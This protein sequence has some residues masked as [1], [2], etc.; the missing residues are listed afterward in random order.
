MNLWAKLVSATQNVLDRIE[1]VINKINSQIFGDDIQEIT[2]SDETEI[3]MYDTSSVLIRKYETLSEKE[4]Q[5]VDKFISKIDISNFE[6]LITY[7]RNQNKISTVLTE[8]LLKTFHDIKEF[9]VDKDI[10]HEEKL[11][12]R[13][14]MEVINEQLTIYKE[15]LEKIN[16]ELELSIVALIKV[17]D[18]ER[19]RLSI[20]EIFDVAERIH[21]KSINRALNEAINRMKVCK[22]VVETQLKTIDNWEPVKQ[23]LSN[24][25][26]AYK[27]TAKEPEIEEK[28]RELLE[29]KMKELLQR[30]QVIFG[31][32]NSSTKEGEEDKE[33]K[34]L[35]EIKTKL[36]I[37]AYTQRDKIEVIRNR[38]KEIAESEEKVK[39]KEA[40][41][42]ELEEIKIRL[43]VFGYY[44]QDEDWK[45]YYETK[46]EVLT[47]DI[48]QI[49]EIP[50]DIEKLNKEELKYYERIIQ[51]KTEEIRTGRNPELNRAFGTENLKIVIRQIK[52][53][54]KG[55]S[56]T[57]N[58]ETILKDIM[59]LRLL[60]A[61]DKEFGVEEIVIKKAQGMTEV[62][63]SFIEWADNVP[64]KTIMQIQRNPE[65][66]FYREKMLIAS[67]NPFIKLF[68][69]CNYLPSDIEEKTTHIVPEGIVRIGN[70][71]YYSEQDIYYYND[72]YTCIVLPST[73]KRLKSMAFR[74]RETKDI[75][76][77]TS[78]N[79]I[80]HIEF[81]DELEEID[82]DVFSYTGYGKM[83]REVLED[84]MKIIPEE[85]PKD[86]V[87]RIKK[88]EALKKR[89]GHYEKYM[90]EMDELEEEI[91]IINAQIKNPPVKDEV[92]I[93]MD[94]LYNKFIFYSIRYKII[95]KYRETPI[96]DSRYEN[97]KNSIYELKFIRLMLL[98]KAGHE[99][100]FKYLDKDSEE[101]KYF[102]EL[103]RM[104]VEE[105]V[106]ESN[107][108]ITTAFGM[109]NKKEA[110]SIIMSLLDKPDVFQDANALKLLFAFENGG[111]ETANI[112]LPK[113]EVLRAGC[114]RYYLL[115][116]WGE[117]IPLSSIIKMM[118]DPEYKNYLENGRY[119]LC[120]DN[121][122]I[123]LVELYNYKKKEIDDKKP[124]TYRFLEGIEWID[125]PYYDRFGIDTDTA[126]IIREGGYTRVVLPS[127]LKRITGGDYYETGRSAFSR[128]ENGKIEEVV[129]NEGL[130]KI[131]ENAFMNSNISKAH[132]PTT[133]RVIAAGAYGCSHLKDLIIPES[134]VEIGN[135]AFKETQVEE[136]TIP[137]SVERMGNYVFS[138]CKVLKRAEVNVKHM[139]AGDFAWCDNLEELVIT[140]NVEDVGLDRIKCKKVRLY[141]N[142]IGYRDKYREKNG[143][144][145]FSKIG[146]LEIMG[147]VQEIV[148]KSYE[149]EVNQIAFRDYKGLLKGYLPHPEK[150]L[151]YEGEST[152]PYLEISKEEWEEEIRKAIKNQSY[153]D[154][155]S[156][157]I[158]NLYKSTMNEWERTDERSRAWHLRCFIDEPSHD[159]VIKNL[160][161]IKMQKMS[162][163]DPN[164]RR[165]FEEYK[166]RRDGIETGC[167][168]AQNKERQ[169][170]LQYEME[171]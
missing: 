65:Y 9:K 146:T 112:Q 39:D 109:K 167:K 120:K 86:R 6:N 46:F 31:E 24:A 89:I 35:A 171:L 156:K 25:I 93:Q 13:L 162:R 160:Y 43:D 83:I 166:R 92:L 137:A 15:E 27:A 48:N 113:Q 55:D 94:D 118:H 107:D 16:K 28:E 101:Y 42:K 12:M 131:G 51:R 80:E 75:E 36:D 78:M 17:F 11:K 41:I 161:E 34:K 33:I 50:F 98:V 84:A 158:R 151:F 29:E 40:L 45:T 70:T 87:E 152:E 129:F 8:L 68:Q 140:Q 60:L 168:K 53:I 148:E 154:R 20:K 141:A 1:N 106:N 150:I 97:I 90:L 18:R 77:D 63:E 153:Q 21:R 133:V 135:C 132:I 74:S 165:I 72:N 104:K 71:T 111:L 159:L 114:G 157:D 124:K 67:D 144:F 95:N 81:N 143:A 170:D 23:M 121:P 147:T 2:S 61:F 149:T 4:Q 96:Q 19:P 145:H 127:S 38:I 37:Y 115:S 10:I 134:V 73:L 44:I 103:L 108:S 30:E 64:I 122:F 66:E 116:R 138:E 59:R 136:V 88:A 76:K 57:F 119:Y 7:G 110:I 99:D 58:I 32:N 164:I 163:V 47:S 128:A 14:E 79:K 3:V 49:D 85:V 22:A 26:E 169:E 126:R 5:K 52:G 142:R 56:G 100:A 82:D 54:L 69:S 123:K 102:V 62:D 125:G 91:K 105:F 130:E 139:G 117:K 155:H